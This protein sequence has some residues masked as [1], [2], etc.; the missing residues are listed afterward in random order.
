MQGTSVV[1]LYR[2]L[3]ECER[4]LDTSSAAS[5]LEFSVGALCGKSR[6]SP[7]LAGLGI[8]LTFAAWRKR[9]SQILPVLGGDG[10]NKRLVAQGLVQAVGVSNY[11]PKQMTRIH[12][13][14]TAR[15]V[16]LAS[17]QVCWM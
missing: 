3:S 16:P 8:N 6:P 1:S 12:R 14:L 17:A 5:K 4:W 10:I 11:G 9:C 15:G 13:Y 2:R 7:F